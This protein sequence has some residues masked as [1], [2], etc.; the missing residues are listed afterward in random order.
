MA[1]CGAEHVGG[2]RSRV[3]H[4]KTGGVRVSKNRWRRGV[5]S[6]RI[7]RGLRPLRRVGPTLAF[8]A[9]LTACV[10]GG[11]T[12]VI[13]AGTAVAGAATPTST[14]STQANDGPNIQVTGVSCP[15][16]SMCV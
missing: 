11:A 4:E 10:L 2:D 8:G 16:T 12:G 5:S 3:Q 14:W 7:E 15:T 9:V 1:R 13:D 6:N